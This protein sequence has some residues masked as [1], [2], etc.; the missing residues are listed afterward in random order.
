MQCALLRTGYIYE[1]MSRTG[2]WEFEQQMLLAAYLKP[3][4]IAVDV[5]ANAGL[6]TLAMAKAV[7]PMGVVHSYEPVWSTFGVLSTNVL[8]NGLSN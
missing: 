2:Q 1:I 6:H 7:G 8:L 4:D 5:G 3:G